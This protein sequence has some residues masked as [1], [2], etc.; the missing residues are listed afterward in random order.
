MFYRSHRYFRSRFGLLSSR[1]TYGDSRVEP[2]LEH[3]MQ[4]AVGMLHTSTV[5]AR[6]A[7]EFMQTGLITVSPDSRVLDIHRMFV[8]EEIHGAPV[9][10]ETGAL[11]GVI[12]TLDLLRA[13]RD[14]AD[15]ED[16]RGDATAADIMTRELV[17]VSPNAPIAEVAKTMRDQRIHRVLVVEKRELVGVITTFD[18]LRAFVREA[19]R[20]G[21]PID[22]DPS[23]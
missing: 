14:D 19:P 17:T 22:F 20:A 5:P 11:Q 10:D 2:C 21:E 16:W 4:R 12:S 1:E 3:L 9:V 8:E 15:R 6:L 13:V 23:A 18:L 7:R